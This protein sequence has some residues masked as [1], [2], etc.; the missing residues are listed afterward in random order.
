MG[1][2]AIALTLLGRLAL[3]ID[4]ASGVRATTTGTTTATAH[5]ATMV[6][7]LTSV[8][9]MG[10]VL[11]ET[12]VVIAIVVVASNAVVAAAARHRRFLR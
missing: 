2:A 3:S 4:R 5:G 11:G 10:T 6:V 9:G 12:A 1:V 8:R 7:V